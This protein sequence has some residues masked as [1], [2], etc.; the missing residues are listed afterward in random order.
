MVFFFCVQLRS[1]K[2]EG[3]LKCHNLTLAL[4]FLMPR[5]LTPT[6]TARAIAKLAENW[7]LA[8][9]AKELLTL[10]VRLASS[11]CTNANEY[12]LI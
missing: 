8:A 9:V 3:V 11:C 4:F 1:S 12:S 10:Q 6:Q 7:S 2:S 5:H